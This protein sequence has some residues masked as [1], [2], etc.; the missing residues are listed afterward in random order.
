MIGLTAR[1]L[2]DN[3]PAPEWLAHTPNG[4]HFLN[5]GPLRGYT[6]LEW[7]EAMRETANMYIQKNLEFSDSAEYIKKFTGPKYKKLVDCFNRT[8]RENNMKTKITSFVKADKY[9]EEIA[10]SK[11]PRM[12]QYRDPGTNVEVNRFLEP[13]EELVLKGPGLGPTKTS[14]CSKGLN[15][16]DRAKL[17]LEK[18]RYFRNPVCLKADFSKFDAHL[19]T[20]ILTIVHWFYENM[21]GIPAGFMDFQFKNKCRTGNIQYTAVGT[22][23]SGDRDT[24]GGNSLVVMFLINTIARLSNTTIE[25]LCDGDDQCIWLESGDEVKFM[26]WLSD[27][28]PKFAGM[29]LE[30]EIARKIEEEEFCHSKLL[31]DGEG[32]WKCYLDPLRTLHRAFWVVNMNGSRRCGEVFKGIVEANRHVSAGL[33]MVHPVM[34]YWHKQTYGMVGVWGEGDRFLKEKLE[35]ERKTRKELQWV[36]DEFMR[37]QVWK[38]WGYTPEFQRQVESAYQHG[39]LCGLK[40]Q[41]QAKNLKIKEV[42]VPINFVNNRAFPWLSGPVRG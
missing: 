10:N 29:K 40:F 22:R 34:D 14:D 25:L 12:I 13:I 30:V 4:T 23:M 16:N 38:Y 37:V 20:H 35:M 1:H 33:P 18:R 28:I 21:M 5:P 41:T 8:H 11:P 36:D 19:H 2:L 26:E 39:Y 7:F 42:P 15:F 31:Q 3:N 24:G 27:V 17:W 32:N 6:Q 9:T